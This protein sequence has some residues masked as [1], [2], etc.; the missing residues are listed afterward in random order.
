VDLLPYRIDAPYWP[1]EYSPFWLRIIRPARKIR[2]WRR[3]RIF[4]VELRGAENVRTALQHGQGILIVAN[5]GGNGDA[6]AM[7]AAGDQVGRD[8]HFLVAWQAFENLGA[9]SSWVLQKHGCFSVNREANDVRAFRQAVEIVQKSPHPL[10]VFAEGEV[11][12]N[13]DHP[14]PFRLGAAGIALAAARRADR[15]IVCIP[16][17]LR[18]QFIQDPTPKLLVLMEKLE[19][20]LLWQPRPDLPLTERIA[21]F[22]QGLL[23]LREVEYLGAAQRGEFARRVTVLIE[24]M[25]QDLESRYATRPTEMDAP[26]RVNH[27][28]RLVLERLD[29]LPAREAA[30]R[31]LERDMEELFR[32]EQLFSYC[33]DYENWPPTMEHLVE[34]FD[35]FEEDVLGVPIA[36]ARAKFRVIVSFGEPLEV[37]KR[38]G[39]EEARYLTAVLERRV[40]AL[41]EELRRSSP[42]LRL[43]TTTAPELVP[44][45]AVVSS[46]VGASERQ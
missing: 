34:L 29:A 1:P 12:H 7:L 18:Y 22:A 8:F 14:A 41:V 17:A 42:E 10:V 5:H 32:I 3:E 19:R 23:A 27:V 6:Y 21:R 30:R 24:T 15:L 26:G 40:Q 11:Y 38:Q 33:Y 45:A 2:T 4:G 9:V 20:K 28:R 13:S 46:G 39:K 37:P 31:P 16:T 25:L 36:R 43:E 35:K 44:Q